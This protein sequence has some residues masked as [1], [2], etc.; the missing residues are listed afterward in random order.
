MHLPNGIPFVVLELAGWAA[1][2]TVTTVNWAL[3]PY[4]LAHVIK[5]SRPAVIFTTPGATGTEVVEEAISI[6]FGNNSAASIS[7][8]QRIYV[9]DAAIEDYGL[10]R[11]HKRIISSSTSP[12]YQDWKTLL[13]DE[14]VQELPLQNFEHGEDEARRRTALILWSSGTSGKSKGVV[15]P[16]TYLTYGMKLLWLGNPYFTGNEVSRRM[17]KVGWAYLIPYTQVFMGLP[18]FFHI[19]GLSNILC[20]SIIIGA[21]T[22]CMPKVSNERGS[23]THHV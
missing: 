2:L 5:E 6:A 12:L 3:K 14:G 21:T 4:E 11:S 10:N 15:I 8:K 7:I 1:G 16:H 20:L 13:Q 9:V 19:L 22:I 23:M 17:Q 18:P